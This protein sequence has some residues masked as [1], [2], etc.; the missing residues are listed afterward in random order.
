MYCIFN[1]LRLPYRHSPHGNMNCMLEIIKRHVI[2]N[3]N[4]KK[5]ARDMQYNK[6]C[7]AGACILEY[8]L[9]RKNFDASG[10]WMYIAVWALDP[11]ETGILRRLHLPCW[12]FSIS[13][14][15]LHMYS[16]DTILKARD[17]MTA[18]SSS[19]YSY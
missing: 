19:N 1:K 2:I 15:P 3:A 9:S 14:K 4:T 7:T 12:I 13:I 18:I 16:L 17:L 6:R 5:Q 8:L 10:A 11:Y